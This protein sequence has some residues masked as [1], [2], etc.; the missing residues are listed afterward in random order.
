[1]DAL[2]RSTLREGLVPP[3]VMEFPGITTGGG[4]AGT[5]GESSSWKHGFFNETINSVELVLGNGDVVT[6]SPDNEHAD[7]F[8][9]AAGAV[10]SLGIAT[11]VEL[12]LIDAKPYVETTYHPVS[13]LSEARQKILEATSDPELEYVD[14]IMYSTTQGAIVTGKLIDHVPEHLSIQSFSGAWDPWFYM[15]VQNKIE[16]LENSQPK[17]TT[18]T[19]TTTTT[20]TTTS[21]TFSEI[22]KIDDFFFRYDRGGFWVGDSA[23]KYTMVPNTKLT[24]WFLDDFLHTRMLY[25]A[26]HAS[27]QSRGYMVQDV[28]LPDDTVEEF[29]E[30]ISEEFNI[31]PLWLCPLKQTP[32]PTLHPHDLRTPPAMEADGVTLKPMLNIGVWGEP[33]NVGLDNAEEFMK[34]EE[35]LETNLLRL[36][37]MKWGYGRH[38]FNEKDFWN[39]F[40]KEWYDTLRLKYHAIYLPTM[41]DKI[42]VDKIEERK[43]TKESWERWILGLWPVG[44]TYAI[45]KAIQSKD[46][47]LHR[48]KKID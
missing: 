18:T 20:S 32:M 4:Y 23:F 45:W 33:K 43:L 36:G 39:M 47:L 6:A 7:L 2:I 48:E 1:M 38:Y 34:A 28:A 5:S 30:Y 22:I 26:L 13:S 27:G 12:Q 37:G 11:L 10:G 29:V 8:H 31:W 19:T 16:N 9:G 15:H 25:R 21:D 42:T 44:G 24:R 14:G 41:H 17:N 35:R 46:Y 40:D 3:V